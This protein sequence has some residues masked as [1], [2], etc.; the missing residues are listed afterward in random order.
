MT[1][2][3]PL[4]TAHAAKL[5]AFSAL[6][7]ARKA[8]EQ[9]EQQGGAEAP[10]SATVKLEEAKSAYQAA[11]RS[12]CEAAVA[13]RVTRYRAVEAKLEEARA[14][15]QAAEEDAEALRAE[16]SS[17][18]TAAATAE[19]RVLEARQRAEAV[20][21]PAL[22]AHLDERVA[23]AEQRRGESLARLVELRKK[24]V[25]RAQDGVVFTARALE[26][27]EERDSVLARERSVVRSLRGSPDEI[28]R[29][30]SSDPSCTV[31]LAALDGLLREWRRGVEGTV[32][33]GMLGGLERLT[34]AVERVGVFFFADTGGVA[35]KVI[36]DARCGSE[37]WPGIV[38]EIRFDEQRTV[39]GLEAERAAREREQ[40]PT[41]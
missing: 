8:V 17:A 34:F 18:E 38:E 37:R 6:M 20:K 21:V 27:A 16:I 25:E 19:E 2:K 41:G 9:A 40:V 1:K 32:R 28:W 22:H 15:A 12:H 24:L 23:Q 7:E 3:T 5:A 11:Q 30:A 29:R 31:D 36:F 33:R 35:G 26:L 10:G 39:A 13:H 14:G 4:E